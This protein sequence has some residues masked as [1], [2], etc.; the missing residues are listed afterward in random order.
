MIPAYCYPS[1]EQNRKVVKFP[2]S[3]MIP[4]YCYPPKRVSIFDPFWR[5]TAPFCA[6]KLLRIYSVFSPRII[7]QCVISRKETTEF[8]FR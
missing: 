7:A 1:G 8:M 2:Y 4:A 5:V 6:E 3:S